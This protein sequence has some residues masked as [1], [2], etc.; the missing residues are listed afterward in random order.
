MNSMS[1]G[2]DTNTPIRRYAFYVAVVVAIAVVGIT[3][4]QFLPHII[5]GWT[6]SLG[7]RSI[8]GLVTMAGAWTALLGM[9]VQFYR[10]IERVN[11]ILLLPTI[12]VLSGVI[13]F[14]TGTVFATLTLVVAA[15]ALV[16][17]VLHPAG[18]SVLRFDR[19]R[20]PNRLLV[21]LWV[22]GAIFLIVYGGQELLKQ[23]TLTGEDALRGHYGDLAIWAFAIAVWGGLAVFRRRDWRFAAWISGF[24]ALYLGVSSAVFPDASSSLGSVSGLLIAIWAITFV[25]TTERVRG[26]Q[27][28]ESGATEKSRGR[29]KNI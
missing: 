13:G 1:S 10:P 24:V 15:I 2:T 23:F 22:V 29:P 27:I 19:V 20:S 16:P 9:A 14:A 3:L 21:G 18:R 6:G 5:L 17:L 12:T 8:F 11:A 4:G 28:E 26:G 7:N 25:A